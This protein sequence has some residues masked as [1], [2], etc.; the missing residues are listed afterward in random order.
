MKFLKLLYQPCFAALGGYKG[1]VSRLNFLVVDVW[2][3]LTLAII[4][5][6]S[7]WK[8]VFF[9]LLGV[10]VILYSILKMG[11][12]VGRLHDL[13]LSGWCLIGF[14]GVMFI[15]GVVLGSSADPRLDSGSLAQGYT[16]LF[17]LLFWL[18]LLVWPSQKEENKWGA[19]PRKKS[20][21]ASSPP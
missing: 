18:W 4:S 17:S 5:L 11:A 12:L 14:S 8:V 13:G 15:L 19:D 16:S 2:G 3:V 6:T 1:R 20:L 9:V 7:Q 21:S 10:W